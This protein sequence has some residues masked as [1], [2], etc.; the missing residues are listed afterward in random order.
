MMVLCFVVGICVY[1]VELDPNIRIFTFIKLI[2]HDFNQG[3][4][5][6]K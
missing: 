4:A 3:S 5:N 6:Y 1:A 2:A